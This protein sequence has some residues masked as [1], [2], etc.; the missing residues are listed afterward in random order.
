MRPLLEPVLSQRKISG[1]LTT[2]CLGAE[3]CGIDAPTRPNLLR[4]YLCPRSI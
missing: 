4:C 2:A 1:G 3:A